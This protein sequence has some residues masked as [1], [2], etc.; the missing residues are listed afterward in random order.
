MATPKKYEHEYKAQ[1]VKAAKERRTFFRSKK[2]L[3]I[4]PP[5]NKPLEI[6]FEKMRKPFL[7]NAGLLD[8]I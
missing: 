4:M 8:V 6:Y 1:A 5:L 3:L 2:G 7:T